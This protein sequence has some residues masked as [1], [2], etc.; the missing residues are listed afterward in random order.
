MIQFNFVVC[1]SDNG[2]TDL[3]V[4]VIV[5]FASTTK[6]GFQNLDEKYYQD[7]L[8]NEVIKIYFER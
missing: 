6:D 8:V 3:T 1:C 7:Y 4:S 2:H 5:A